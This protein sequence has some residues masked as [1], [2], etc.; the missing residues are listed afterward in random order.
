MAQMTEVGKTVL[1]IDILRNNQV[2]GNGSGVVVGVGR[3]TI[4]L[5][6]DHV[7][8]GNP[9]NLRVIGPDGKQYKV[10]G[11]QNEVQHFVID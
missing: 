4:V 1:K 10:G 2:V 3:K 7:A 9:S 8:K 5:T 11:F 6:N